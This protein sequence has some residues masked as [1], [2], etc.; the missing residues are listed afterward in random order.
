MM[1]CSGLARCI[2]RSPPTRETALRCTSRRRCIP[3]M[4]VG[5][6]EARDDYVYGLDIP[7]KERSAGLEE[8]ID[9]ELEKRGVPRTEAWVER[10][11]LYSDSLDGFDEG[12]HRLRGSDE[13][14]RILELRRGISRTRRRSWWREVYDQIS[15]SS[16]DDG[17]EAG[18][19]PSRPTSR[20]LS[21]KVIIKTST[22]WEHG[23]SLC[24]PSRHRHIQRSS[25]LLVSRRVRNV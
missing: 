3:G 8:Q 16:R 24:A 13:R 11:R 14:D 2:G 1:S 20:R 22:K 23:Q 19:A 18:S 21:R 25:A 7:R 15:R 10:Q 9:A 6:T 5:G 12:G 17:P 4:S